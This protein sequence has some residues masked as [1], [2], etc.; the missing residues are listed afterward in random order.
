MIDNLLVQA[1]AEYGYAKQYYL[2]GAPEQ[3][4]LLYHGALEHLLRWS[5]I[6]HGAA[7]TVATDPRQVDWEVLT[8]YLAA[9]CGVKREACDFLLQTTDLRDRVRAGEHP[10]M[11]SKTMQWYEQLVTDLFRRL[12]PATEAERREVEERAAFA[13]PR[14]VET[15]PADTEPPTPDPEAVPPAATPLAQPP[16]PSA[17]PLTEQ[18]P[19]A[20]APPVV[21]ADMELRRRAL[22][23]GQ[24]LREMRLRGA[25]YCPRCR[26]E[27]PM[28]ADACPNCGYDLAAYRAARRPPAAPQGGVL[29]RL[30][31]FLRG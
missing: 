30:R 21:E 18:A 3:A 7:P 17:G 29:E 31:G 6:R 26:E 28:T 9:R 22:E 1:Q 24:R 11:N 23:S 20:D 19:A 10:Q 2:D 5:M 4:L 15:P 8:D 13:R 12:F 16:E 14:P 27:A 25:E